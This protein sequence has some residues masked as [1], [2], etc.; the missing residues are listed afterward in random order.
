LQGPVSLYDYFLARVRRNLRVAVSLD[1][2]SAQLRSRLEANPALL[3]VCAVQ[4][5]RGMSDGSLMQLTECR[6]K[7][8]W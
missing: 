7:V 3:N 1:A 5:W 4:W 2:S 8:G 6:L